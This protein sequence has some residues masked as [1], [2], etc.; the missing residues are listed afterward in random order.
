M[1][2]LAYYQQLA[3]QGILQPDPA[4]V[5]A[6]ES[7]QVVCDDLL[8]HHKASGWLRLR[9]PKLTKGLYLWGG[10][11]IGKTL[12]MDCFFHCLTIPNK[13]RLHFH[14]FMRM[15]HQA[16][17]ELQGQPNPLQIY[18]KT[19][20]KKYKVICLDEFNVTDIVDAM[21]LAGL[22]EALFKA[23]VS[24]VTTSNTT[25]DELY[26]N[27][28]QRTSFLPAIALIHAHL[29]V[30]HLPAIVDYRY[31]QIKKSGTFY[32]P[33]DDLAEQHMQQIFSSLTHG[34]EVVIEPLHMND[35]A[36]IARQ[37]TQD[38]IWFDFDELCEIPRSQHDY[39]AITEQYKIVFL[40]HVPKLSAVGKNRA[41]LFAR[42]ID[43]MY[44]AK[45]PLI[46][47]SA[48]PIQELFTNVALPEVPRIMSRLME[49]QS[50][51]Y[52]QT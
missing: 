9:K 8:H 16:L 50:E 13:L 10:V 46:L 2:L 28:L 1:Q 11:G 42:L 40:S 52:L 47:S 36:I 26:K 34:H 30:L 3:D 29:H 4:Q 15:V 45:K 48:L 39:L 49:M 41:L 20:A 6:L 19:L 27:G 38:I 32:T 21:L 7:L 23:G 5:T 43:V 24:L 22:L 17:A 37:R 14:A 12:L 18:A 51:R 25:P 33:D 35:R 31:L 44:D